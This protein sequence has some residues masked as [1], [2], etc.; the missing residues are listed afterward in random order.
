MSLFFVV[1]A[2]P[3]THRFSRITSGTITFSDKSIV[4]VGALSGDGT[5]TPIQMQPVTTNS[6]LFKVSSVS[7][8]CQNAGLTE[9][10]V[11]GYL[12]SAPPSSSAAAKVSS[13]AVSSVAATSSDSIKAAA[14]FAAPKSSVTPSSSVPHSSASASS[15]SSASASKSSVASS[16]S[17]V[18]SSSA[19]SS[20]SSQRSSSSVVSSSS[21]SSSAVKSSS[22]TQSSST[23]TPAAEETGAQNADAQLP[24]ST[25]YPNSGSQWSDIALSA[26]ATA[27]SAERDSPAKAAIDGKIDGYPRNE[28]AEWVTV[29]K[30]AGA[31]IKL[32]WS[33]PQTINSIA[34]YDRPNLDE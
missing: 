18:P 27:S 25:I 23:I 26:T 17:V 9:I 2:S 13:S 3:L 14:R 16:S 32:T 19:S 15:F 22:S 30:G 20:S 34:L 24:A 4:Q 7:D 12:A 29:G 21:S 33:S 8:T 11:Q 28:A 31:W 5:A 6:L 1:L 10:V